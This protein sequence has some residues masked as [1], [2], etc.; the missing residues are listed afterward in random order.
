MDAGT[1]ITS[2]E[3]IPAAYRHGYD[4]K[5][6]LAGESE[7]RESEDAEATLCNATHE[8]GQKNGVLTA[9]EDFMKEHEGDCYF[10]RVR[11]LNGMGIMQYRRHAFGEGLAFAALVGKTLRYDFEG[12]IQPAGKILALQPRVAPDKREISN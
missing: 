7:L 9:I 4:R 2:P 10:W 6:P 1:C 3:L 8:D 5:A 11:R 12:S